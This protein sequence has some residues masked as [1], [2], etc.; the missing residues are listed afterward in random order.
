MHPLLPP[1]SLNCAVEFACYVFTAIGAVVS[2]L[3]M[4]RV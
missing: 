4:L 2:Y 1:E 3:F